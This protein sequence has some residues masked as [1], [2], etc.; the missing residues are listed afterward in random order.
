MDLFNANGTTEP[1]DLGGLVY[2]RGF[3]LANQTQLLADLNAILAI[4]PLRQMMTP[5]GFAMSVSTSSCGS[6]G[7]VSDQQGY[8]YSSIDPIRQTA[9]PI[10][11]ESFSTLANTAA[12]IAGYPDFE[13]DSCLINQYQIGTKMGL[14]Q[15]KNECDFSQPIVSISLGIAARFQFGGKKRSDKPLQLRL[16]HGDVIVWGGD[17]RLNYHGIMTMQAGHHPLLGQTRINLTFRKAS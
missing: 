10:M 17:T 1:I 5:M 12:D 2:L 16:E 15:D 7:W 4:A 11:P 3:A 13:P 9:W 14:H 6:L 8:R